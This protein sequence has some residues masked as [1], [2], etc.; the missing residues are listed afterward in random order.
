M[1]HYLPPR[2]LGGLEAPAFRIS[3]SPGLSTV[4]PKNRMLLEARREGRKE[5][6]TTPGSHALLPSPILPCIHPIMLSAIPSTAPRDPNGFHRGP[7]PT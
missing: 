6:R 1:G 3:Q 5:A 7:T 4:G 2:I